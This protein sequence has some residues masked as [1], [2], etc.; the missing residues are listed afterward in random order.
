MSDK[1]IEEAGIVGATK[2]VKF[3]IECDWLAVLG[4]KVKESTIS[5]DRI[6]WTIS[7]VNKK[8]KI[9]EFCVLTW[10]E[11]QDILSP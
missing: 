9:I 10:N 11:I 8:K 3:I 1:Q 7:F 6:G 2:A 5:S 4:Y